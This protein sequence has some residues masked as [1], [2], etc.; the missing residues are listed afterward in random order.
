MEMRAIEGSI[1]NLP[2]PGDRH[3]T[4]SIALLTAKMISLHDS[5]TI[6][7][8]KLKPSQLGFIGFRV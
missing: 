3:F 1:P 6:R 2:P 5:S 8:Q 7:L 4:S